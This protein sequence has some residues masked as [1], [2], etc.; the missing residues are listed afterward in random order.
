MYIVLGFCVS[1]LLS[2]AVFPAFYKRAVRL[3][4][5]AID[6]T[7]PS[8]YAEVRAAQDQALARH[9]VEFR[10]LERRL[11]TE[12]DALTAQKRQSGEL[13]A[14]LVNLQEAHAAD[15]VSLRT[16]LDVANAK[17]EAAKAVRQD[18]ET[19]KA[20]IESMERTLAAVRNE[21]EGLR[22]ERDAKLGWLPPD[23][24]A[25]AS[26]VSSLE[27]EI[28]VLK[29]RLAEAETRAASSVLLRP[30]LDQGNE[31]A[32]IANLERQLID[33]EAKYIS[34]QSD[35][36]RLTAQ[37]DFTSG[38]R[39]GQSEHTDNELRAI[40][41]DR[42]RLK[43]ELHDR[44]RTLAR[45]RTKL[46]QL[47]RDLNQPLLADMR[48]ELHEIVQA[49]LASKSSANAK[50]GTANKNSDMAGTAKPGKSKTPR[51]GQVG[52]EQGVDVP[53]KQG[54]KAAEVP[55]DTH[56]VPSAARDLVR[57]VVNAQ[58]GAVTGS[59]AD[60]TASVSAREKGEKTDPA[61]PKRKTKQTSP[62]Q[63]AKKM[64]VA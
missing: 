22:R 34:A 54:Q 42:A 59:A 8:T 48:K 64:G 60:Q 53:N 52:A 1:G 32:I 31:R 10:R 28:A 56:P 25:A 13:Q 57:R 19:A 51:R 15:L 9:A 20:R 16:E 41:A 37:L 6:A 33:S 24:M 58:R 50:A 35:V 55:A 2:L 61:A 63:P 12:R 17:I 29:T 39:A 21:A 36:T 38:A 11:E 30:E 27:R 43:A 3:T 40:Q 23:D 4:K 7:N 26:T 14:Q 47:Q 46:Q 18:L 45:A 5:E 44:D 62:S 49:I